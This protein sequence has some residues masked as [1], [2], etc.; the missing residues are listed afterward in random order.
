MLAPLIRP[1][2]LSDCQ[3]CL[4]L[5]ASRQTSSPDDLAENTW[6]AVNRAVEVWLR[7]LRE[8]AFDRGQRTVAAGLSEASSNIK[9]PI[10]NRPS[11]NTGV[12]TAYSL[13][14]TSCC[15]QKVSPVA[16][17]KD[18]TDSCV[19]TINCRFPPAV[20]TVGELG[21]S[22]SSRARHTSLPSSLLS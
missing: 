10:N 9:P 12:D 5:V 22:D 20:M 1:V 18:V 11:R 19:Q 14:V 6:L 3:T 8:G 16:G 4:P 2:T 21:V 15:R 13:L 17:S 7:I